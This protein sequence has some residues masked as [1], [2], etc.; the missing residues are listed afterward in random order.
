MR[1]VS[2]GGNRSRFTITAVRTAVQDGSARL[3]KM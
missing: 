1:H 3:V 2:S